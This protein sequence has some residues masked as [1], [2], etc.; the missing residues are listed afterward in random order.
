MDPLTYKVKAVGRL[1]NLLYALC[2]AIKVCQK[3]GCNIEIE[4]SK[5]RPRTVDVNKNIRFD[6]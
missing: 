6:N 2:N 4:K 5:K 1:G 3:N